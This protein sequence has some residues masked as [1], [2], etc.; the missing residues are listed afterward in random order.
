MIFNFGQSFVHR[1]ELLP[2]NGVMFTIK[3]FFRIRKMKG[4]LLVVCC[5]FCFRGINAQEMDFSEHLYDFGT[6]TET[7]GPVVHDFYFMNAGEKPLRIKE[8]VT[9]CGCIAS[10]WPAKPVL[11]GEKA[12]VRLKYQ[13]EHRL[14]KEFFGVAEVYTNAGLKTLEMTG[15]IKRYGSQKP[16]DYLLQKQTVPGSAPTAVPDKGFGLILKRMREGMLN[17]VNPVQNDSLVGMQTLLLRKGGWWEDVDYACYGRTNWEPVRH[18]DRVYR[19]ALAYVQ[20]ESEYYANDILYLAIQDALGYWVKRKPKCHNWWYNEIAVPQRLGNI[21]VLMDAGR[22]PL[23]D[24]LRQELFGLMAW[25]D[26]RKWTGANKQDIAL[27]HVQRGCLLKNDSIVKAA[28]EQL[29]YPLRFTNREG[30]QVDYSYHQHGNQ[31]YLG[32][33]GAVFVGCVL[34]TAEWFQDTPYALQ[35]GPLEIFSRFV[36]HTYLNVFRGPYLDYSVLG[37]GISRKGA[38]FGGGMPVLLERMKGIDREHAEEYERLKARFAGHS[39]SCRTESSRVFWRSDYA[40]HN[41]KTFDFSVR[42]SSVR[43]YKIESGNGE[44]LKGALLSE[45]ATCLRMDGNEYYDFFPLWNWNRIPGVTAPEV[46]PELSPAAWGKWGKAVFSGGVSEG[47]YSVMGYQMDDFGVKARK[48]WFMFDE[49]VVCLGA[50]I[51]GKTS[52]KVCTTVEQCSREGRDFRRE[53]N[54]VWL[55]KVLYYF[56]EGGVIKTETPEWQSGRWSDINYNQASGWIRKPGFTL[57]IDHGNGP[58][59]ARYA[60]ILAPG[61]QKMEDYDTTQVVIVRNDTLVQAVYQRKADVLQLVSY[62]NVQFEGQGIRLETDIPC[63]M[64]VKGVKTARPS[65]YLA[66]PTQSKKVA[67]VHFKTAREDIVREVKLPENDWKGSTIEII[68]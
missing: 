63:V 23:P 10:E 1:E 27:H 13:P 2:S 40:L 67:H 65:L 57:W 26:P 64:M 18:L 20:P 44:N 61:I 56:P 32:G 35:Q 11:P 6:I 25:P 53:E 17:G 15:K 54:K 5:V 29:F 47:H 41:R 45:G 59:N 16:G 43:T 49:E 3:Y 46:N 58:Q 12:F 37:R 21:L 38:T 7:D 31:L 52:G 9:S 68:R 51:C 36:R 62:G 30:L 4:I 14:E 39:D 48:A 60:Y 28:V 34:R 66:D 55:G 50:G 33:Y 8:V 22:K 19:Q 24:K 42:T